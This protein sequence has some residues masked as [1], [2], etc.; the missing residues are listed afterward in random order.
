FLLIY[1]LFSMA[2]G[3]SIVLYALYLSALGYGT[4]F[5]GLQIL[6]GTLGAGLTLVPAGISVDRFGGKPL[7]FCAGVLIVAGAVIHLLLRTPGWLLVAAFIGGMGGAIVLVLYSPF[8]TRN[9]S[10]A[11]RPHLFSLTIV[12][13]LVSVVLGEVLGGAL[14]IFLLAHSWSMLP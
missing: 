11:E 2:S 7:F 14:P 6:V 12:V 3:I 8:L 4:D 13:N 1:T 10:P 5:I 9:S